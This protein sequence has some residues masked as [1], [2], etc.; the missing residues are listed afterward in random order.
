MKR[1]AKLK[2][3]MVVL[4]SAFVSVVVQG[5]EGGVFP[6]VFDLASLDGSNGFLITGKNGGGEVRNSFSA[7]IAGDVNGDGIDD[8]IIGD[9]GANGEAGQSY[10]IFGSKEP[11]PETISL[12][13]LNGKNGFII[14][15]INAGDRSGFAVSGAGDVNGDGIG[16][17]IIGAPF[18]NDEAGQSYVVFGSRELR[19]SIF[20]LD[21][22]NGVNG[23]ILNGIE[24]GDK[25]GISVSGVGDVN[26]DGVDDVIIGAQDAG[27]EAG[28]SY[29]VFGSRQPWA[30]SMELGDL[31]GVNGF[32]L[33]GM[34]RGDKSGLSVSGAGDVNGDGIADFVVGA[35][36]ANDKA[37]QSYVVLGSQERWSRSVGLND[38]NGTRGFNGTNGFVFNGISAGDFSGVAVS[39]AGDINGDGLG[40]ILVGAL[41]VN[42]GSNKRAGQSYIVFGN[43]NQTEG[44]K[45]IDFADLDGKIGFAVNGIASDDESGVSLSGVGDINNDGIADVIIGAPTA[46]NYAGQSYVVFGSKESWPRSINL[47]DLNGRNGFTINGIISGGLIG[48]SLSGGGDVNGDGIA[49]MIIGGDSRAPVY[50][51]FGCCAESPASDSTVLELALEIGGGVLGLTAMGVTAYYVYQNYYHGGDSGIQYSVL[52]QVVG[53]E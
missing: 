31:N 51:I 2:R 53:D 9:M 25:S 6:R 10:V 38:Y 12:F 36:Y 45:V 23:F 35:C 21:G 17:I 19:S 41:D 42:I 16:D 28:Q 32:I 46:R 39:G 13:D 50:V 30:R 52:E 37:G 20:Y 7:S 48:N 24:G 22:L 4:T 43:S 27:Y 11:W 44:L 49:D 40:D 15:G 3:G 1:F 5:Q 14:N 18:A 29:V 47:N 8:V 26:G 33:N 34:N